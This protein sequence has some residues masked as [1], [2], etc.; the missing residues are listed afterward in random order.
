V[1]RQDGRRRDRVAQIRVGITGHREDRLGNGDLAALRARVADIL[2]VISRIGDGRVTIISPLADGA[3]QLVAEE[4]LAAGFRLE[5]PLPFPLDDYAL[6]FG[7]DVGDLRALLARAAVV[8]EL[9]GSRTTPEARRAAYTAVGERVVRDADLLLAIWD[10]QEARGEGG[11][12]DIVALG[13]RRGLPIIWIDAGPPHPVEVLNI[14]GDE[15]RELVD[16]I[17]T[18]ERDQLRNG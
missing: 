16:L 2:T 18:P 15:W 8:E 9:P 5:C 6:D 7:E 4:A 12:A 11:T 13:R 14:A 17:A 10:G 1:Q 3:D